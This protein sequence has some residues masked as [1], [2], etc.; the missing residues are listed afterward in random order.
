MVTQSKTIKLFLI[1]GVL[2]GRVKVTIAYWTGLAYRIPR[3]ELDK[4]E[5]LEELTRS[6]VYFLFGTAEESGKDEV[7]IGQAGVG[8]NGEGVLHRLMEHNRNLDKDS[9]ADAVVFTTTSNNSFKPAERSYL[10]NRFRNL[11]I[12]A[13]RYIVKK[14][15]APSPVRITVE[16][17][18]ELDKF[19]DN[20]KIVMGTLGRKVFEPLLQTAPATS[21][22]D[23]SVTE[24]G[25]VFA[26]DENNVDAKGRSEV[27]ESPLQTAPASPSVD[28]SVSESGVVYVLKRNDADAQGRRAGKGIVVFA[29]SLISKGLSMFAPPSIKKTRRKFKKFVDENFR[30]TEDLHFGSPSAASGFVLGSSSS[31]LRDWKTAEGKTLKDVESRK[32]S[33]GG[34]VSESGVVYFIKAKGVDA[35]GRRVGKG[36]WVLTGSLIRKELS[37][38]ASD[39]IM[40]DRKKYRKS[41]DANCRLINDLFFTKPSSAAAF[42]FGRSSNGWREWINAEGKTLD[43]VERKR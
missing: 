19:A 8:K 38:F 41:V 1:D 22:V 4:C 17:T 12:D 10:E 31:G 39:S 36:I 26:I 3:T 23:R 42:V 2:A 35:K 29:G 15:N 32:R 5:E 24:S 21:S 16:K 18:S 43:E 25:M 33:A 37:E 27:F 40:D 28:G 20:A 7:Y 30:L 34:P 9:W 6:G 13:K 11:A 14:G